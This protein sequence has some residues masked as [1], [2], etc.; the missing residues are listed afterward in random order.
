[1]SR[2][3]GSARAENTSERASCSTTRLNIR[4]AV[5]FVNHLVEDGS[6]EP[7]W[8]RTGGSGSGSTVRGYERLF[9]HFPAVWEAVMTVTQS[10]KEG[11]A[12]ALGE[13][14]TERLEAEITRVRRTTRRGRV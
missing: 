11:G 12:R 1:M 7:R 5:A 14:A 6:A 13:V 2:R 10:R 4:G 8:R 3:V 9:D